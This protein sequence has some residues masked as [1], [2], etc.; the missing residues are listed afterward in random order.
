MSGSPCAEFL[1]NL[2]HDRGYVCRSMG[3]NSILRSGKI[4][5]REGGCRIVYGAWGRAE[6]GWSELAF[7]ECFWKPGS[8]REE[9]GAV[10][11]RIIV[12]AWRNFEA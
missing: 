8:S 7:V 9:D 2:R 3:R 6:R 10:A 4:K 12:E 5:R 1:A 11:V